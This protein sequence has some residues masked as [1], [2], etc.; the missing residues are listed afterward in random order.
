M[1]YKMVLIAT[2]FRR[3]VMISFNNQQIPSIVI[4]FSLANK[5]QDSDN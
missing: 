4:L 2:S 3:Q 5:K 1:G